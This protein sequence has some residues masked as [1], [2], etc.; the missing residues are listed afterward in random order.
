M[1]TDVQVAHAHEWTD[2]KYVMVA[3]YLAV[4]TA[5]EVALSYVHVAAAPWLPTVALLLLMV[6]KFVT[7]VLFFMHLRFDD[8]MFGFCVCGCADHVPNLGEVAFTRWGFLRCNPGL[9]NRI[10]KFG[11]S[12]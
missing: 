7:V 1:M 12:S 10:P 9:F 5:I 3:F 6:V 8:K 2:K 11:C 4:L